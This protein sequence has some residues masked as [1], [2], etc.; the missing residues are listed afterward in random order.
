MNKKRIRLFWIACREVFERHFGN[1]IKK[2]IK[3]AIEEFEIFDGQ[4]LAISIDSASNVTKAVDELI[5]EMYGE[6]ED[7][8]DEEETYAGEIPTSVAD[9]FEN[10]EEFS[11]PITAS[12]GEHDPVTGRVHCTAHRLQLGV[13][14]MLTCNRS[15]R[16]ALS[17]ARR[18]AATLRT[19]NIRIL[20]SA[21]EFN[22][23]V[24]DQQTRWSSQL[25]MLECAAPKTILHF[26]AGGI[27]EP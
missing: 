26:T 2:W 23:A 20:V 25:R 27:R 5:A 24:L 14:A 8:N 15:C 12:P 7:D 16:N 4:I 13:N 19:P 3:D 10:D 22:H 6:P 18:L 11:I 17:F 21:S 9:G 1:N